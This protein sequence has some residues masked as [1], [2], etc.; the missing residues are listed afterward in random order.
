MSHSFGTEF[1]DGTGELLSIDYVAN[2]QSLGCAAFRARTSD[3]LDDALAAAR[4]ST[5]PVVVECHV[6]PLPTPDSGAWWDL[7]VPQVADDAAVAE[8]ARSHRA[9]VASQRFYG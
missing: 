2:A 7:G 1:R 5:A 8:A 9:G 4:E 3:Q 6:D